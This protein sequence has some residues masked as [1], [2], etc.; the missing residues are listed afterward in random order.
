[1][2]YFITALQKLTILLIL[3]FSVLAQPTHAQTWRYGEKYQVAS[4]KGLESTFLVHQNRTNTGWRVS[5]TMKVIP[6]FNQILFTILDGHQT[7]TRTVNKTHVAQKVPTKGDPFIAFSIPIDDLELMKTASAVIIELGKASYTFS[8]NGAKGPLT[9]LTDLYGNGAQQKN[10]KQ[11][12]I[13]QSVS[14]CDKEAG[15]PFDHNKT[16][17][18]KDWDTL[19][20]KRAIHACQYAFSNTTGTLRT[21]MQYQ[22]A[23]AQDKAGNMV[24][25][26]INLLE[27]GDKN[28]YAPALNHL[29]VF[30][31]NGEMGTK[32]KPVALEYYR[33]SGGS[34][35]VVGQYNFARLQLQMDP[36]DA[37][38]ALAY[39][40][41]DAAAGMG[42]LKAQTLLNRLR[43]ADK[44]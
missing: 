11:D 8:L 23:R 41:L 16:G 37:E 10:S 13:D 20:S 28:G 7:L 1:M 14:D 5:V 2:R 26:N 27:S 34:A 4:V 6:D 31:E 32:S 18:G 30:A 17:S 3:T 33:K 15:N 22:L 42:Y 29:G 40:V 35:F 25:A 12:G 24:S 21:R 38:R 36:T 44:N 39:Q 43:E 9:R 19:E